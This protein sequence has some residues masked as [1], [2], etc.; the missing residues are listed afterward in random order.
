MDEFE[1]LGLK[2]GIWQ[3]L[4]YR[5]TAPGRLLLVH[6]GNPVEAAQASAREEGVW[7]IA[8]AI[9]ARNLSEGVQSFLLVE[10]DGS[11]D[12]PL[13]PGARQLSALSIMAGQAIDQDL[14]VE[15]GLLRAEL[16][17][18][19]HEVRRLARVTA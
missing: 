5:S 14:L 10:D 17:L 8:V 3:G 16:N 9:P 6:G 11:E 4:L 13:Q 15:I 18:L 12:A 1:S 19:K 7:A 2:N